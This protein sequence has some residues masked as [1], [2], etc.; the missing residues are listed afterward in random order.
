MKKNYY[1]KTKIKL[2]IITFSLIIFVTK[3]YYSYFY[4][5][6]EVAA[7]IIFE[8]V[9][10]GYYNLVPLKILANLNLNNSF[11]PLI[12]NLG[13]VPIPFGAFIIHFIFYLFIGT[14]SFIILEFFFI[15]F[16]LII[17]YRISRLLNLSQI[18]SL[19]VAIILF[20]IPNVLQ[21][22]NLHNVQYFTVIFSEFYSL[23][24]PRPMISNIFFFLFIFFL[25]KS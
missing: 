2:F 12:D 13:T 3:W 7:R 1:N 18:Q 16:F 9:S 22:L 8:S 20:N 21:L 14:F 24:F 11:S 6:E 25:L 5:N 4:F 19:V 15:I 10:D 17:F 23:R